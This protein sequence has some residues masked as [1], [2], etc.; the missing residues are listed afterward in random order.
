MVARHP[1]SLARKRSRRA[2]TPEL[3]ERAGVLLASTAGS[4]AVDATVVAPAA[5]RGDLVVSGDD[6]DLRELAE[7]VSG[8]IVERLR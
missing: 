3:A 8:V 6:H 1:P 7:F 5:L 2:L 4:N